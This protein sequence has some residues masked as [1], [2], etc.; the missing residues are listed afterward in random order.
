MPTSSSA[1][2]WTCWGLCTST[3]TQQQSKWASV[4][5]ALSM[6][7]SPSRCW[8]PGPARGMNTQPQ[9]VL[10]SGCRDFPC[11][12][13]CLTLIVPLLC[14]CGMRSIRQEDNMNL[15]LD[16]VP[17]GSV[18]QSLQ[19]YLKVGDFKHI[20]LLNV[21]NLYLVFV[22]SCHLWGDLNKHLLLAPVPRCRR[23][24]WSIGASV[25][26]QSLHISTRSWLCQS[27]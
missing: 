24:V 16:L 23:A 6:L 12:R 4:T 13:C 15:F 19:D 14:R 2:C 10:F 8:A 9:T 11:C 18:S 27:E 17:G 21:V 5:P 26:L 25:V 3:C 7:T 22:C 20:A 1:V